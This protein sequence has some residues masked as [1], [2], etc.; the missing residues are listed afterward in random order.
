MKKRIISLLAC[1]VIAAGATA[2]LTGCGDKGIT[3][4]AP[5]TQQTLVKE[6]ID[7][8]LKENTDFKIPIKFG[9]CGEDMAYANMSKDV[10]ASADVYGYAN[11]QLMNLKKINAVAKLGESA[12]AKII[13]DND[14]K[15]V[16][17]CEINGEYYGYPYAADNGYF[18]YYDSSVVSATEAQTLEGVLSAC[19]KAGKY[20]LFNQKEAWY[21]GTFFFGAGGDYT[22]EWEGTSIKKAGSDF[23]QKPEGS[24]YSYGEIG[25]MAHID[26]NAHKNFVNADDSVIDQYLS[27]NMLGAC[28]SGTWNAAKLSEKLGDNYAAT[29]L[30]TFHSSLTD[31]DYQMKSFAG[32]KCFGVNP[33]SKHLAEAHQIAAFLSGKAMQEKR[34]DALQIGPS[35]KEVAAMDKVKSNVALAALL[36]QAPHSKTQ[37][38]LP[39]SYWDPM[40]AFGEGVNGTSPK[41]NRDNYKEYVKTFINDLKTDN[42]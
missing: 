35:N 1:G 23:D 9:V 7:E 33:K 42:T 30:P 38:S 12:K 15:S 21:V 22:I 25:A 27:G 17:S 39:S 10:E 8:F 31:Q 4:W 32:Y 24:E 29:K 6:M 26:L 41:I 14:A 40:K 18:M 2:G 37:E 34:F 16:A 36:A 3:I 20:F 19:A 13:A 11:D 28:V 5:Q